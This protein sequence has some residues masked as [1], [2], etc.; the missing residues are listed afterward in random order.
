MEQI[1]EY[2]G[3]VYFRAEGLVD[4]LIDRMD[5]IGLD[6]TV[7]SDE[8]TPDDTRV[9]KDQLRGFAKAT[10]VIVDEYILL[11]NDM[12]R[13]RVYLEHSDKLERIINESD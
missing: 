11:T 9:A 13:A 12:E 7:Y 3:Q 5:S 10:K 6:I 4:L 8:W 2:D 1:L